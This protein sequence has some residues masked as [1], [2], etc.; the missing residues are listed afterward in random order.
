MEKELSD[1]FN[2]KFL[3]T[4]EI[5]LNKSENLFNNCYNP[6]NL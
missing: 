2:K 5:I 1:Y 6:F 3:S 4:I